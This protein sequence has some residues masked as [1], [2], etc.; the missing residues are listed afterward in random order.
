MKGFAR[1]CPD[2]SLERQEAGFSNYNLIILDYV[3]Y[4]SNKSFDIS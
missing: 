3:A 1:L 4:S 2:K